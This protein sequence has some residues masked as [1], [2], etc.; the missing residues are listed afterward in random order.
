MCVWHTHRRMRTHATTHILASK[1]AHLCSKA[2][3]NLQ[4][5]MVACCQVWTHRFRPFRPAM[6]RKKFWVSDPIR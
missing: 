6:F 4:L 2:A 1:K 5:G 3:I